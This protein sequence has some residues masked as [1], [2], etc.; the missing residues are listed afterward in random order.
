MFNFV[1]YDDHKGILEEQ[2]KIIQK[3]MMK[4]DDLY[5]IHKFCKYNNQLSK[6]IKEKHEQTVYILDVEVPEKSGIDI[7]REIRKNDWES[8]IIIVT[9][10]SE[11]LLQVFKDRLML[12]DFISKF[13]NREKRLKET[14]IASLDIFNKDKKIEIK[15]G[16]IIHKINQKDILYI[17]KEK[18]SHKVL[19]VTNSMKYSTYNSID[20]ISKMLSMNFIKIQ[21]NLIINR[22][23]IK[24]VDKENKKVVLTNKSEINVSVKA[25]KELKECEFAWYSN[26]IINNGNSN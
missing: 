26:I 8:I 10:H 25:V 1:L 14:I 6:F 7:A 3:I 13:D 12:F 21:R 23:Y 20:K 19:V 18:D 15:V 22:A 5:K 11:L 4:S 16:N 9:A 2:E 17:E 24:Q